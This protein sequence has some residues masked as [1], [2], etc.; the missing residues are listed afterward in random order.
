MWGGKWFLMKYLQ[1]LLNYYMFSERYPL[2]YGVPTRIWTRRNGWKSQD[3]T[4]GAWFSW[5]NLLK[6]SDLS[7]AK[8]RELDKKIRLVERRNTI[9]KKKYWAKRKTQEED[10]KNRQNQGCTKYFLS[11]IQSFSQRNCLTKRGIVY[12]KKM[13]QKSG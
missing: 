4:F 13:Q 11:G 1:H 6:S 3:A 10:V 2:R 8:M 12:I 7:L 5:L 9:N